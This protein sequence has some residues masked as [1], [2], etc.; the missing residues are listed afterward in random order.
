MSA[1]TAA[2]LTEARADQI[3]E[4][5]R[6]V[7]ETTSAL[8]HRLMRQAATLYLQ[9]YAANDPE[10]GRNERQYAL[11]VAAEV[12][13]ELE[14]ISDQEV[15]ESDDY[16]WRRVIARGM[17]IACRRLSRRFWL[18]DDYDTSEACEHAAQ[19]ITARA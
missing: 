2:E 16:I 9:F 17:S 15:L 19:L 1:V 5:V 13:S 12:R 3:D 7:L 6:R 10:P 4:C 11:R 18:I 8:Q 14:Q